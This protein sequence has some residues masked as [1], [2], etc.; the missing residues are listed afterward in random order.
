MKTIA[1]Q[2][3][4]ILDRFACKIIKQCATDELIRVE[5]ND[6]VCYQTFDALGWPENFSEVLAEALERLIEIGLE[7]TQD[8][9]H[10]TLSLKLGVNFKADTICLI[11]ILI[12][13][14][15]PHFIKKNLARGKSNFFGR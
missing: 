4:R 3:L 10:T 15:L 11:G 8:A 14:S 7:P 2:I 1:H 9:L 13:G 5:I 6:S 12:G